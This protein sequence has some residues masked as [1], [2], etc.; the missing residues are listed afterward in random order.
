MLT[1][2][3]TIYRS[4]LQERTQ[5]GKCLARGHESATQSFQFL[6]Q[7]PHSALGNVCF[8]YFVLKVAG[9]SPLQ[10]GLNSKLVQ[11]R[12]LMYRAAIKEGVLFSE[13]IDFTLSGLFH[14]CCIL[15]LL[16]SHLLH[17]VLETDTVATQSS[18][19]TPSV[20]HRPVY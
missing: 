15:C 3:G 19:L 10:P 1:V 18:S 6:S 14:H 16:I 2:A 13:N 9:L 11:V 20:S 7:T 8:R 17:T 5:P 4:K 12:F